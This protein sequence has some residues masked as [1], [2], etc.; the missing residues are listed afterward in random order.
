MK[1]PSMKPITIMICTY[2]G[3]KYLKKVLESILNQTSFKQ[4]VEEIIV[5]DNSSTDSTKNII[6][7]MSNLYSVIKYEF[8]NTQGLSYGRKHIAHVKTKWVL[9]FDD[10]NVLLDHCL[11][12]YYQ[13]VNQSE[14]VGVVNGNS[15][16]YP[17]F[18]INDWEKVKLKRLCTSLA[19]THLSYEN[20]F[21]PVNE[22][23]TYFGAG[24]MLL[25]QPVHAFIN[26]GGWLK[27]TGRCKESLSSGE[28]TEL[29][30]IIFDLGYQHGYAKD[31]WFYHYIPRKRLEDGYITNLVTSLAKSNYINLSNKNYY[32]LRRIKR[33]IIA[34]KDLMVFL[35]VNENEFDRYF[36][37]YINK[38]NAITILK[39]IWKDKL[40]FNHF[41]KDKC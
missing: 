24:M 12:G 25:V 8:E 37:C 18:E 23:L 41:R 13:I 7:D 22:N 4:I 19:C 35:V 40:V 28:D 31:A 14:Q 16:A 34:I 26:K 11:E 5:V 2:N 30:Q 29:M 21:L 6:L 17:D 15:I 1:E 32:L 10:D 33:G 36:N 20:N 38:I 3:E 27:N 9:F 39:L